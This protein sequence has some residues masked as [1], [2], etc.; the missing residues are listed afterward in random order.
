MGIDHEDAAA[1]RR[2]GEKLRTS[3]RLRATLT[4]HNV[5]FRNPVLL[6]DHPKAV[7]EYRKLVAI[8]Q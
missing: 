2:H 7:G 6:Q 5:R 3:E 8:T 4:Q 1:G